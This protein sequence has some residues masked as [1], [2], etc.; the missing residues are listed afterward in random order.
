MLFKVK[1]ILVFHAALVPSRNTAFL[2]SQG[3]A[4]LFKAGKAEIYKKKAFCPI[5]ESLMGEHGDVM[6]AARLADRCTPASNTPLSFSL[7]CHIVQL[8][9]GLDLASVAVY[10]AHDVGGRWCGMEPLTSI[11]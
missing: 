9:S 10:A 11:S 5:R 6:L 4:F 3:R 7:P 2:W 8:L 1:Y